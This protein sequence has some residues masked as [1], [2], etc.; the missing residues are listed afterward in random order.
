MIEAVA[1]ALHCLGQEGLHTSLEARKEGLIYLDGRVSVWGPDLFLGG[2]NLERPF[3]LGG[4]MLE[5][6]EILCQKPHTLISWD[7]PTMASY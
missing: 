6:R 7:T 3:N 1:Y 4:Q 2:E 5:P